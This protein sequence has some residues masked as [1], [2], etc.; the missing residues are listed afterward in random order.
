MDDQRLRPPRKTLKQLAAEAARRKLEKPRP[1]NSSFQ[2]S[3]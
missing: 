1:R 3:L 2:S